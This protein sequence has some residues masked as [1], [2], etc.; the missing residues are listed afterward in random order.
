MKNQLNSGESAASSPQPA[1]DV[2]G[3]VSTSGPARDDDQALATLQRADIS[4]EEIVSL[5]RNPGTLK[6]RK[7]L[8]ALVSHS[9]TPRHVSIPLLRRMFTFDLVQV[10]VMPAVAADIK[11]AAEEQVLVRL[12][13]LPAGQKISLARRGPGRIAAELLAESDPRIASVALDNGRLVEA[14]VV[15]AL[16]KRDTPAL[17]YRLVG[18]HPKWSLR[19]EVQVALLRSEKT[20]LERARQIAMHFSNETL[21][22]ILPEAR[23]SELNPP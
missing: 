8:L 16:M 23:R 22:E 14:A 15:A 5:S 21:S 7:V 10:A 1:A 12:E 17:L 9:R 6:S 18:E 4:A 20:P 13:S 3:S 19:R 2:A 11:R